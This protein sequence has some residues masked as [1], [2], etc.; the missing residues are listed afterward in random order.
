[1]RTQRTISRSHSEVLHQTSAVRIARMPLAV[2]SLTNRMLAHKEP[3]LIL[4]VAHR[5]RS[6]Q[7]I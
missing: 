2:I 3:F 4:R 5:M 6:M 7:E 1:M